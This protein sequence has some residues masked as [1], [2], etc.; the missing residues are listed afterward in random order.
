[1]RMWV[2]LQK[3]KDNTV[4]AASCTNEQIT[5]MIKRT[6]YVT[7]VHNSAD[8]TPKVLDVLSSFTQWRPWSESWHT[9]TKQLRGANEIPLSYIHRKHTTVTLEIVNMTYPD[10]DTEYC[11]TFALSGIDYEVENVL[12]YDTLKPLLINGP[13]WTIICPYGKT[14]DR[15]GA[16]RS[17]ITQVEGYLSKKIS[18][19]A[20]YHAISAARNRGAHK[21]L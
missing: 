19:S 1:M 5:L 6:A 11:N 4:L 14:G 16:I 21:K 2:I 12:Y 13:G 20:A 9:Y 17:L 10:T 8:S 18:L 7:S 15:R 3:R